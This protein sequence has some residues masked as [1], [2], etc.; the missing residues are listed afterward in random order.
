MDD[1]W[2]ALVLTSV[3]FGAAGYVFAKK[4]GRNPA[5]WTVMGLLLNVVVVIFL[6]AKSN[7]NRS[8]G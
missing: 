1:M 2:L 6:A 4:T 7:P 3:V 8:R 5:L